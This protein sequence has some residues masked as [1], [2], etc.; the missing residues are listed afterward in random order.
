MTKDDY[1]RL[2][3]LL[4]LLTRKHPLIRAAANGQQLPGD[5]AGEEVQIIGQTAAAAFAECEA[6]IDEWLA[7]RQSRPTA[8]ETAKTAAKQSKI[9]RLALANEAKAKSGNLGGRPKCNKEKA[10]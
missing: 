3:S 5:D 8:R 10:K 7:S 1:R 6:K 9:A 4:C 2:S